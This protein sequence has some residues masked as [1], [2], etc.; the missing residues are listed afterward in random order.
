[1]NT[2]GELVGINTAIASQTGSYSGYS[3]AIPVNLVQK[4][5]NDL[6]DYGVAQRGYL[7]IQIADI[8]QELKEDRNLPNLLGVFVAGAVEN[9]SAAKSGIKAGDV[10]LKIGSKK[11]NSVASL[12][13]E[14]GRKR[15]GD[16]ISVTIRNSKGYEEV[17]Q[18][19]LR[20]ADGETKLVSKKI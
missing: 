4:V 11:V 12:Q 18:I 19:V 7:G 9:G 6:I 3:F 20:N 17:K 16:S 10:I 2:R 14:V 13:E 8:S 15:P 5:M 1:M